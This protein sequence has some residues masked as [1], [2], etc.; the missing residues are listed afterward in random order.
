MKKFLSVQ[1]LI[2]L[3]QSSC[4]TTVVEAVNFQLITETIVF[5]VT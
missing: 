5:S 1:H 2:W 4:G 3:S